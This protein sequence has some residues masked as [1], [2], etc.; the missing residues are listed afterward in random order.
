MPTVTVESVTASPVE[1][2][3]AAETVES[4][5]VK[6][7]AKVS[8]PFIMYRRTGECPAVALIIGVLMV[9]PHRLLKTQT[10]NPVVSHCRQGVP[11]RAILVMR[12]Q[13]AHSTN[14]PWTWVI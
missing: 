10:Y 11:T 1:F 5:K 14:A 2:T 7:A 13:N 9:F 8:R 12:R 4:V 6:E 3:S